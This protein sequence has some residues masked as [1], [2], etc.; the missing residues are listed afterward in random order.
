MTEM[1][2]AS[3]NRSHHE[4]E[5]NVIVRVEDEI[6]MERAMIDY[7]EYIQTPSM[8]YFWVTG[9][10]K[11]FLGRFRLGFD[12]TFYFW[13]FLFVLV[14]FGSAV[15]LYTDP[16]DVQTTWVILLGNY[17]LYGTYLYLGRIEEVYMNRVRKANAAYEFAR[18][19]RDMFAILAYGVLLT[20][21]LNPTPE[22][23]VVFAMLAQVDYWLRHCAMIVEHVYYVRLLDF[24][25]VGFLIMLLTHFVPQEIMESTLYKDGATEIQ[26]K[27]VCLIALMCMHSA[28]SFFSLWRIFA[29][30]AEEVPRSK[31][32]YKTLAKVYLYTVL[33]IVLILAWEVFWV[34]V[35]DTKGFVK[36]PWH[37]LIAGSALWGILLMDNCSSRILQQP[38]TLIHVDHLVLLAFSLL[39][40]PADL[41]VV[42][43]SG[44]TTLMALLLVQAIYV[45]AK[46]YLN[47][48]MVVRKMGTLAT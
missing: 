25:E 30:I 36:E 26:T 22:E 18:H 29:K 15:L 35:F 43:N 13:V 37:F 23:F 34:F 19:M 27:T 7:N 10:E 12:I 9:P 5:L 24:H 46:R 11:H 3:N 1:S 48:K 38:L 45:F 4:R 21:A 16:P 41:W 40:Y 47:I 14:E 39:I 31:R 6:S 32:W 28:N 42:K 20:F 8:F 17:L 2:M 44:V 33:P